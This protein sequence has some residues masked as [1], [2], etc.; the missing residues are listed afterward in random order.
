VQLSWFPASLSS[1]CKYVEYIYG[2]FVSS[3][4]TQ[5]QLD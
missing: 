3:C 5:L 1:R 4:L 2:C